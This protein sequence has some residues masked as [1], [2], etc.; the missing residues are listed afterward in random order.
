VFAT[1]SWLEALAQTGPLHRLAIPAPA[2]DIP[3]GR[4]PR[5]RKAALAPARTSSPVASRAAPPAAPSSRSAARAPSPTSCRKSAERPTKSVSL[6]TSTTA[7]FSLPASARPTSPSAACR[8]A[9]LAAAASPFLRS[10]SYAASSA[11]PLE[12]RQDCGTMRHA[13]GLR[14]NRAEGVRGLSGREVVRWLQ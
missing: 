3:P 6:L 13:M 4:G 8:E 11:Q 2:A 12:A 14:R 5:R 7:A 10:A 1:A 9:L